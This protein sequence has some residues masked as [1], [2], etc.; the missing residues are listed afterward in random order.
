MAEIT[1]EAVRALRERTDLPMMECKKA[2]TEANGDQEA[3]VKIL[4]ER[5]KGFKEKSKDRV[6]SEGRIATLTAADG[7]SA[8]MIDLRCESAPVSRSEG[9]L[10][11]ADQL[12]KQLLNGPGAN[13]PEELMAQTCPDRADV[14][15][16]DLH[17]EVINKI[18]ESIVLSRLIK[19][20]GPVGAY[21]HHDGSLGV[22]LQA[23]GTNAT[24]PVL[25]DVAMHIAALNPKV[26]LPSEL[27]PAAVAA[28]K[29][30]Q[31]AEARASK[32]PENIIEKIVTGKMQLFYD[33][34][35]VLVAQR[36]AKDDTK[37]VEKAL[38]DAGLTA[39]GFTRWR[40]GQ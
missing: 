10:L 29:E 8:V 32:K 2:L 22:L 7:M 17:D 21:T 11:L 24:A 6:T 9:F 25:R 15:L 1:A 28:E 37:T 16:S 33:N 5:V 13:S 26:C 27:D 40:L 23:S 31:V 12:T 36:F 35:G 3:A 30:K 19:V 18:R 4:K 34:E 20:A 39:V 38:A 14:K